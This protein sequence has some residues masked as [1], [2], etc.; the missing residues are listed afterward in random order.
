MRS[1]PRQTTA[2]LAAATLTVLLAACGDDAPS[3]PLA[4]P[5]QADGTCAADA[6]DACWTWSAVH[7]WAG[8]GCFDDTFATCTSGGVDAGASVTCWQVTYPDGGTARYITSDTSERF[9][10][11]WT[12]EA[13][14]DAECTDAFDRPCTP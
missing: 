14:N 11:D 9:P 13:T 5:E 2:L 1:A 12:V 7:E 8:G 4:C 3:E 6:P 10:A